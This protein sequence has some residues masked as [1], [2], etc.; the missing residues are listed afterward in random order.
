MADLLNSKQLGNKGEDLASEYLQNL[1]YKILDRNYK[2]LFGEIDIIAKKGKTIAIVEVK[3]RISSNK[4]QNFF[5]E[6]NIT[7]EKQKKLLK[8][9]SFFISQSKEYSDY[10]WEIDVVAVEINQENQA[11]IRFLKQAITA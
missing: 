4:E 10:A 5:P 2:T 8:L 9:G 1:G 7:I 11:N 6:D 3:T